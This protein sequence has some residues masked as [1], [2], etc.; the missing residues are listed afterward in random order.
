MMSLTAFP[1]AVPTGSLLSKPNALLSDTDC[2]E[3]LPD[4]PHEGQEL[5]RTE[6]FEVF[7][8]DG[9]DATTPASYR[10]D[11]CVA[12]ARTVTRVPLTGWWRTAR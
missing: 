12:D 3:S 8:P 7:E 6:V 9:W 10:P 2:C 11:A 4:R 1:P 5:A